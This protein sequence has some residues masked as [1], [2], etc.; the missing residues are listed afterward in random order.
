MLYIIDNP[1]EIESLLKEQ[2]G[3][4]VTAIAYNNTVTHLLDIHPTNDHYTKT[5]Y[6]VE[7]PYFKVAFLLED[8][9]SVEYEELSY[10]VL[11][12]VT[13]ILKEV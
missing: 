7:T 4:V 13:I 1:K 12:N 5:L 2:D 6:T 8:I 3:K 10:G 11:H 9:K